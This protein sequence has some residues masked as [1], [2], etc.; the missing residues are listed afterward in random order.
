MRKKVCFVL[1]WLK[2]KEKQK[3]ER[4]KLFQILF[5]WFRIPSSIPVSSHGNINEF[6]N[7][8]GDLSLQTP[9]RRWFIGS[10][11]IIQVKGLDLNILKRKLLFPLPLSSIPLF[12]LFEWNKINIL[13]CGMS[14]DGTLLRMEPYGSTNTH[15]KYHQSLHQKHRGTC[16]NSSDIISSNMIYD[17]FDCIDTILQNQIYEFSL[18]IWVTYL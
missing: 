10:S 16:S 5:E 17:I 2:Q 14:D 11:A 15:R 7:Q 9:C 6:F 12:F 3:K 8:E 4:K 13:P 1:L 18:I